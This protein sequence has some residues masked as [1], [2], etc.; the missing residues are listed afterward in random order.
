M[1]RESLEDTAQ[2]FSLDVG[3][4]NELLAK[5][6]AQLYAQRLKRPKPHRDD[7]ILTAW[8]GKNITVMGSLGRGD[9]VMVQ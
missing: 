5:C 3:V 7:K 2:H 1:V 6:R 8:N 9:R 4:A